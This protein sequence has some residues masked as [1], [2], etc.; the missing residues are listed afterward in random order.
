MK[1]IFYILFKNK[2]ASIFVT[3]MTLCLFM[4]TSLLYL[5]MTYHDKIA[6]LYS[7]RE[8]R[9]AKMMIHIVCKDMDKNIKKKAII[10]NTGTVYIDKK[11]EDIL[12]LTCVLKNGKQIY[13]EITLKQKTEPSS[14]E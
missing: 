9:L 2:Q 11:E 5:Q 7:E 8:N 14:K 1:R 12:L 6:M 3:V 10:F 13:Q 4:I